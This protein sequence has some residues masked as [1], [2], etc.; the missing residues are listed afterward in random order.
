MLRARA[1]LMASV[2]GFFAERDVLEVETPVVVGAPNADPHIA[3]LCTNVNLAGSVSRAY[4]RTS[5][6]HAMKRL[7]AAHGAPIYQMGKVFRDAEASARHNPEFTLLEWYRPG[8]DHEALMDE[9]EA[10]V[11]LA[12]PGLVTCSMSY[13]EAFVR[14][15]NL[16]PWD[17]SEADIYAACVK[18]GGRLPA[19]ELDRDVCL[20]M[21]L[22]VAVIPG[23]AKEEQGVFLHGYPASQAGLAR[24]MPADDTTAARF[25]LFINGVELANGYWELTDPEEQRRRFE[26]ERA[27]RNVAGD[28]EFP[29]DE[30]L[31]AALSAG[32]PDCAGVA[33]GIDRLLML[34]TH[35][36]SIDD[37]LTFPYARA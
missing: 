33:M 17:A 36:A 30:H 14:W 7:L 37:V 23:L 31:L 26:H 27:R 18:H 32:L 20:D 24:M 35:S 19:S 6:E 25:E 29:L 13:R 11:R 5:P 21:L 10:L 22:T 15:A 9:V 2:R 28:A 34:M 3:S 12:I 1:A 4:L 16:D 8:W